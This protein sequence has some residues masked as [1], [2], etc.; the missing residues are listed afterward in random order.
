MKKSRLGKVGKA[1]LSALLDEGAFFV[2][3]VLPNSAHLIPTARKIFNRDDSYRKNYNRAQTISRLIDNSYVRVISKDGKYKLELTN[4]GLRALGRHRSTHR[5]PRK[6]DGKWRIVSFDVYE[7]ARQRRDQFRRELK[8]YGFVQLH[9]S[10]WV[11]PYDCEVFIE[12][13]R[14]DMHFGRNIQYIL[15][16]RISNDIALKKH[17]KL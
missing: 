17:F 8:E 15:A 14:T 3:E 9:K 1:I 12:L 10:L 11:Y 4:E 7:K 2:T 6:W 13:L 5:T 16:D